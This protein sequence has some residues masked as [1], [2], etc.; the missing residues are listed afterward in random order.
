MAALFERAGLGSTDAKF[1][2]KLVYFAN[3]A[4]AVADRV[5]IGTQQTAT[6]LKKGDVAGAAAAVG[7][8]VK[9]VTGAGTGMVESVVHDQLQTAK[10]ASAVAQLALGKGSAV[11]HLDT[12]SDYALHQATKAVV[13]AAAGSGVRA[14]TGGGV[15]RPTLQQLEA[16]EAQALRGLEGPSAPSSKA[17]PRYGP[18][19][20]E[21]NRGGLPNILAEQELISRPART[22]FGGDAVRGRTTPLEKIK[23]DKAAIEFYTDEPGDVHPTNREVQWPMEEGKR[24]KIEVARVKAADGTITEVK[25]GQ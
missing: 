19:T 8:T 16:L 10:A 23:G 3:P 11:K 1:V 20:H 17:G 5:G 24:L 12:L 4:A 15:R 22:G 14:S 13:A 18:F 6:A 9:D 7:R 2:A 25:K 21:I